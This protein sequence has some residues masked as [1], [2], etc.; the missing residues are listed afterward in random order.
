MDFSLEFSTIFLEKLRNLDKS[1][2]IEI[3]NKVDKIQKNP[4]LPAQRMQH[5][6]NFFRVYVRNFRIIYKVEESR[7]LLLDIIKRKEG[8]GKFRG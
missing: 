3:E 1:I 7:V 8:Y 6:S 2:A 5:S 4:I